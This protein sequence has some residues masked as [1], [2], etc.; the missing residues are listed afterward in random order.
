M[1][2]ELRPTLF[3]KKEGDI[4]LNLSKIRVRGKR[5]QD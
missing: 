4:D 1:G 3:I 5:P 2:K